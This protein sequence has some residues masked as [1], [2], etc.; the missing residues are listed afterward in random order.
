[1]KNFRLI[2]FTSI[3]LLLTNP[4]WAQTDFPFF[5]DMDNQTETEANWT[6]STGWANVSNI[7]ARSG[8][9]IWAYTEANPLNYLTLTESMDLSG[10][11]ALNPKLSFWVRT[12]GG[13]SYLY[14]EVSTNGGTSW[15]NLISNQ[16]YNT[17]TW[18]NVQLML[19]NYRSDDVKVRI[20]A[21]N[22]S[23]NL[24]LE[25]VLIDNAPNPQVL[26]LS[27]ATNNGMTLTWNEDAS[28]DFD[29][30]RVM[31]STSQSNLNTYS[32]EANSNTL[33]VRNERI[34]FSVENQS[35]LTKIFS[36][37]MGNPLRFNNKTYYGRIWC[38]DDQ[39]LYNQ[40]SEVASLAT[41][42]DMDL[43]IAP[44]TQTFDG[45]PE[46]QWAGDMGWTIT[47]IQDGVEGH[48]SP[49][50]Y[51]SNPGGN[52][53]RNS[54]R[55]LTSIWSIPYAMTDPILT[56]NHRFQLASGDLSYLEYSLNGST[57][58]K[59]EQYGGSQVSG[60]KSQEF[61][62]SF[63]RQNSPTQPVYIRF[64][65]DINDDGNQSTGW[66]IDDV[67]ISQNQRT[68]VTFP[69][70]DDFENEE[71]SENYWIFSNWSNE[72][73]ANPHAG[74]RAAQSNP[75]TGSGDN[76]NT[77]VSWM[78]LGT[79]I[80]LSMASN[81]YLSFWTRPNWNSSNDPTMYIDVSYD[82]GLTWSQI[83]DQRLTDEYNNWKRIQVKLYRR[84]DVRI[85]IGTR[86]Y[87]S[88]N[89][90]YSPQLWIDDV[91]IGDQPYLLYP[92]SQST[93]KPLCLNFLW[94]GTQTSGYSH[95]M[96]DNNS[97][98]SSPEINE[99]ELAGGT[100]YSCAELEENTR[101]YWKVRG[102]NPET[103]WTSA[104]YFNTGT[105][106][107]DPISS[108]ILIAPENGADGVPTS[109]TFQWT[110]VDDAD[111]Y[112]LQVSISPVFDPVLFDGTTSG[113]THQLTDLEYGGTYYWR[114]KAVSADSQSPYT[115]PWIFS[116][117]GN[118]TT[119]EVTAPLQGYWENETHGYASAI[120]ELWSGTTLETATFQYEA[121][122]SYGA[123]GTL[124]A[125][126]NNMMA[127]NY[128]IVIRA[129]GHVPVASASAIYIPNNM[130][131]EYDFSSGAN[132][133]YGTAATV[134]KN[135]IYVIRGG[136]LNGD[137]N[138]T[139]SDLN[140]S[141]IPNFGQFN[142]GEVPSR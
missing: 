35:E 47:D 121:A 109:P 20:G 132:K 96:V 36:R 140:N 51:E 69:F 135:G 141:F 87:Y 71:L 104:Y 32:N 114:A 58:Y 78:N 9:R 113:T 84:N 28:T 76:G 139:A 74:L 107:F 60:W 136:D 83:L 79:P 86:R 21:N 116:V 106:N 49:N 94:K 12:N 130:T 77:L 103:D 31:L 17:N 54:D 134:L 3:I 123:N 82:G 119:V 62:V 97:D 142:P 65:M 37:E 129:V 81:P 68:E 138:V 10:D 63:L 61:S 120:V 105:N 88:Y 73:T 11:N 127:G 111:Y 38:V 133:A 99:D 70:Y 90:G 126:F 46:P 66:M 41:T 124:L 53:E 100:Y 131:T 6:A 23:G 91:Y 5:D 40:G 29:Y 24:W 30:Y 52:Y 16:S 67:A 42:Y 89:Y 1:M 7:N 19:N 102:I 72:E 13:Y 55:Y 125:E 128:W 15:S 48:S 64:L 34:V 56:F 95:L 98:F 122:C 18:T 27:D 4:L 75:T 59:Y 33:S 39:G 118:I 85:R 14:V 137:G 115:V 57:W 101:Y 25:D 43:E 2:V 8:N 80:D 26:T 50:C 117:G 44:K 45:T 92:Q 93:D 22:S 108:P 112:N 110:E